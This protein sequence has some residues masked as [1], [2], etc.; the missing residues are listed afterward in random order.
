MRSQFDV[1][2]I[3]AGAAGLAAGARLATTSLSVI[4]LEARD[5]VGGRAHTIHPRPDLPL[6]LGCGWLHSADENP[7]VAPIEAAG[8][9]I[10]RSPPHWQRQSDNRHFSRADQAAFNRAFEAFD[11]RVAAAAE[12]GEDRPAA[13]F[14]EPNGPWNAMID[15]VSAYYNGAEFDR[16][17][18]VDYAAYHDSEVNFRVRDGYGAAIAALG[19]TAPVMLDCAVERIDHGAT[20]IRITTTRGTLS[21]RAVIVAVP[22]PLV[23]AC[24]PSFD[25]PLPRKQAAAEG[26]PL[27]LADK[28]FLALD[29]VDDLAVEGHLFGEPHRTATG[30]YHLRPFGRPYIEA[31]LG[32]RHAAGLE[33]E[34]PG[35]ATAF[36]VDELVN[37]MG[38]AFR[39]RLS[40]IVETTWA[41]DPWSLGSYSHA[42]PGRAD[43][44]AT[45]A[46]P[47]DQRLFFAG[48]AV[49]AHAFSTA[50]G[51]WETGIAAAEAA[52]AALA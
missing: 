7:L 37:L 16:V 36:A 21:A 5:R 49:S 31:F 51:A 18:T 44:R 50:H 8:W 17:S 42:L 10:D 19:A 27:G 41:S 29:R 43:E 12:R 40:P 30:S 1:V 9:V 4:V 11:E 14:F 47:V 33:R 46:Q 2:V 20:L 32:G 15:A 35:G 39:A 52:I 45:L 24:R 22:T 13:D 38:S 23:A 6:D 28:V 48:E 26:L 3:G 25:P 34:G